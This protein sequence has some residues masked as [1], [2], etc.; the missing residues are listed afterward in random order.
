MSIYIYIYRFELV[1]DLIT[2]LCNK[3]G[4][5]YNNLVDP[6]RV[7]LCDHGVLGHGQPPGL[8]GLSSGT[9]SFLNPS[10]FITLIEN[11]IYYLIDQF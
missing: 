10:I 9:S 4:V 3:W 1:Y 2:Y 8:T 5:L 7:E 6:H 11:R